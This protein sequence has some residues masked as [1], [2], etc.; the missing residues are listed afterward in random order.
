MKNGIYLLDVDAWT[1][2]AVETLRLSTKT[3][4]T[5]PTDT[6]ANTVYAGR[7][8][9]AGQLERSLF[10]DGG[11]T[12]AP[13]ASSGAIEFVN[14]DGRLDPW[15]GYGF[16]GR[17]FTLRYLADAKL[18]ISS[19]SLVM[20]GTCLRVEAT[21][22]MRVLRLQIRD[23]LARFQTPLLTARYAGT[24]TSAGATAEGDA[25]QKDQIKPRVFGAV[26]NIAP[27]FVNRFNLVYQV[28]AGAVSSIVVYDGAVPL[29][30]AGDYPT[31]AV[32]VDAAV[33]SGAFATC[34]A[35]G[36]F[37]LGGSPVF[38]VTADAVE[39]AT[40]ADRTAARIVGRMLDL[41]GVT[42]AERVAASF[43]A[44]DAFNSAE[45]GVF[46]E[47]ES[48]ALDLMGAVLNSVGGGLLPSAD[49]AVE[50]F[51]FAEPVGP[52][53]TTYTRRDLLSSGSSLA[54]IG[55]PSGE[56]EGIPAWSVVVNHARVWQTMSSGDVAGAVTTERRDY[57]AK[58][59]RQATAQN[60]ATRTARL[61][62]SEI[63][64]DTLLT[65]PAAAAVEASRRLGLFGV[66]RDRF[67][68]PV[69]ISRAVEIGAVV[70]LQ[71]RRFG[72]DGG[73]LFRVIG[74]TDD[75][76]ERT[77]ALTLWG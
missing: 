77:A 66:R 71:M 74:R 53:V 4:A 9:D 70:R 38:T 59:Y 17:P 16:D 1:G 22:A 65:S 43:T 27:R 68:F 54:L 24:T 64:I 73:K 13:S 45:V 48:S 67:V 63:T 21:D 72:Y 42:T 6:P 34:L 31:L 30:F 14:T 20:R 7:I 12:G 76:S 25:D 51:S 5:K 15:L 56:G 33:P 11:I 44:L 3:I 19:A 29:N 26:Q 52:P 60:P 39:G 37:R 8:S 2:A 55:A 69:D 75:F 58:A 36:L 47:D 32:M 40:A 18:P 28:S 35:A 57:L 41:F 61:L 46:I 23:R 10:A 50:L 49:G 62:A